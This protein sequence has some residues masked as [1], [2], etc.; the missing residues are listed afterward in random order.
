MAMTKDL[1]FRGRE[2]K[3]EGERRQNFKEKRARLEAM[4]L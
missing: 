3:E 4:V 2:I 1:W